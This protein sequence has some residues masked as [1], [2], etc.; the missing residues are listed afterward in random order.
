[1]Y[2][3]TCNNPNQFP[4]SS[5]N[6]GYLAVN[7]YF[8]YSSYDSYNKTQ[9]YNFYYNTSQQQY[10]NYNE[11]YSPSNSN[12]SSFNSSIYSSTCTNTGDSV[13]SSSYLSPDLC[14]S[15]L[16]TEIL[17]YSSFN[18]TSSPSINLMNNDFYITSSSSP[19]VPKYNQDNSIQ[20]CESTEVVTHLTSSP[21]LPFSYKT[22]KTKSKKTVSKK[23]QLSEHAVGI[24]NEWFEDHLN[25]PYPTS[26]EKE[27]LAALGK[28]TVKQVTAWFSNRRNRTQN[29]KPKRMKRVL[30]KEITDI[31]QELVQSTDKQQIIEKFKHSLVN[32]DLYF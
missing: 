14:L 28:I 20:N 19:Q 21:L 1:M 32:R 5:S 3:P 11:I 13:T 15:P 31:F 25:N 22:E 12:T 2:Q 18:N 27:R 6:Y 16:K 23:Q 30:E 8:P 7:N 9:N 17:N 24:M 4:Y 26:E 10:Y 29:T